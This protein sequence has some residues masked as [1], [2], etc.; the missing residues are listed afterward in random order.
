MLS[1]DM[2]SG[3]NGRTIPLLGAITSVASRLESSFIFWFL[4]MT[5]SPEKINNLKEIYCEQNF[6]F[7]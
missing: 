3:A 2:E 7:I 4:W 5:D 1:K 6:C